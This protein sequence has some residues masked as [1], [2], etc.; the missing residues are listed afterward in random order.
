M[1]KSI[2]FLTTLLT[3]IILSSFTN[4][5]PNEFIGTYRVYGSDPSQIKLIPLI[6]MIIFNSLYF[7][8]LLKL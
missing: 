8:N 7:I 5:N 4:K 2:K 1:T 3:I 6:P